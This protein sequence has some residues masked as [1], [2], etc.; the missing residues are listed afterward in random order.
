ML[1]SENREPNKDI[2]ELERI[3]MLENRMRKPGKPIN[4]EESLRSIKSTDSKRVYSHKE[5]IIIFEERSEGSGDEQKIDEHRLQEELK[6]NRK[7]TEYF[8]KSSAKK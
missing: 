1:N 6:N 4:N 7:I 2:D 5:K 8:P 3:R